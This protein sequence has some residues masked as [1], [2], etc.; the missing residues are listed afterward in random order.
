M[1]D[2]KHTPTPWGDN[3]NGIILGNLDNYEFEAPIVCVVGPD[4]DYEDETSEAWKQRRADTEHIVR[5]VNA[6]D[7]ML[8]NLQNLT[9]IIEMGLANNL[10]QNYE[11]SDEVDCKDEV[12][13]ALEDAKEIAAKVT[14]G[15]K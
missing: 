10:W 6:H 4:S 1:S 13:S 11:S 3:D 8:Q 9:N 14:G 5:C 15:A 12:R 2:T 7:E